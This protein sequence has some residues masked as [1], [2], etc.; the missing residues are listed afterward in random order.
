MR[1]LRH[2]L[3]VFGCLF[4]IAPPAAL[5]QQALTLSFGGFVV[6]GE[7]A[8][9]DGDVLVANRDILSFDIDDFTGGSIGIEWLLP[10]G[11][12]FE[13]GLGAGFTSRTVPSVY[14]DLVNRN[15]DEIEQDLKLRVAPFTA[16]VRVLP[17]GRSRAVQPYLG[18]GIGLFSY[19]YS[20]VGEFVDFT[21]RSVF[22]DQFVAT[23]SEVGPVALAGVRFPLGDAW[24]LGGEVRYQ[25]ASADLSED[26]LGTKLDL[27]GFHYL[28]TVRV[29]F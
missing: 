5:A 3:F 1:V 11:E 8:R 26:F 16:T 9:V 10:V 2:A 20:E 24:S 7:D 22:R 23:G 4:A 15:G 27:S 18:G 19:R 21:D 25:K 17:F 12:F 13:A 14:G 6:A 29:K 28:A